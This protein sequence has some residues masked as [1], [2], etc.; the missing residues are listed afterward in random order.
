[1]QQ[2]VLLIPICSKL[3]DMLIHIN[4][5]VNTFMRAVNYFNTDCYMNEFHATVDA[6]MNLVFELSKIYLKQ[7]K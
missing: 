5:F 4:I 6:R 7:L 1:M 3:L 2:I